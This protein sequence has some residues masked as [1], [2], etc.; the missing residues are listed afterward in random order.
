M[1]KLGPYARDIVLARPDGRTREARLLK[2]VRQELTKH[3]G[4]KL[5]APQ[6]ALV[7]RVAYL[8]L[9]CAVLDR[10]IIDGSFSDFDSKQYLAFSNSLRRA[11]SSLGLDA[12][13]PAKMD[14]AE[15]IR[16]LSGE[17]EAVA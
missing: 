1:P 4:G 14:P 9:R 2:Q 3:L 10:R 12:A 13:A 11:L 5:T 16:L 15:Y 8:Q 6:R 7:E 17:P